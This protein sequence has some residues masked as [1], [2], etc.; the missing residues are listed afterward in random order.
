LKFVL[1]PLELEVVSSPAAP[2]GVFCRLSPFSN[3]SGL[4]QWKVDLQESFSHPFLRSRAVPAV[5]L[6]GLPPAV[7]GVPAVKPISSDPSLFV[8]RDVPGVKCPPR[9]SRR[10]F[11]FFFFTVGTLIRFV[12]SLSPP[13]SLKSTA[14]RVGFSFHG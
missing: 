3:G 2:G 13:P 14:R 4:Q 8:S 11:F 12:F 1:D 6:P 10:L 5:F 9:G 7:G